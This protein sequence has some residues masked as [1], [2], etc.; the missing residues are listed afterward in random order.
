MIKAYFLTC[1]CFL[2]CQVSAQ[3]KKDYRILTDKLCER[4]QVLDDHNLNNS[5]PVVFEELV[6]DFINQH[7]KEDP[8]KIIAKIALN[9]SNSCDVYKGFLE[10]I[11]SANSGDE[12]IYDVRPAYHLSAE[13]CTRFKNEEE[14]HYPATGDKFVNVIFTEKLWQDFFHDQTT[15]V[16]HVDWG[17]DC[18]FRLIFI[19]S[20]NAERNKLISP[21][22]EFYYQIIDETEDAWI[23]I[24][25]IYGAKY[26]KAKL[27]KGP[28]G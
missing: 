12:E 28:A 7:P 22:A 25:E 15:T 3:S 1:I 27:Y 4:M 21:G 20:D 2:F 6:I 19:R 10:S 5:I 17:N 14:F 9:L 24:T 26:L 18:S 13:A 16:N 8:N 23:M 11:H